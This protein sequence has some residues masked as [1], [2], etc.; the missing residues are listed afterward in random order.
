MA[1]RSLFSILSE[2]PWWVSLLVAAALFTLGGFIFPPV[3]PFIALPFAVIALYFAWKQLTTVSP[4]KVEERLAALRAMPWEQ[5]NRVV[6]EAY[7][8]RGYSVEPSRNAAFDFKLKKSGLIT[9][10][11]C[12]R[13]KVN[14]VGLAPV[15]DLYDEM[16]QHG[17]FNAVCIAAHEFSGGAR[18]F[19]AGKPLTL[20]GGRALAELVG[21]VERSSAR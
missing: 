14:Q 15:R 1:K 11:Q 8:R 5:F 21:P 2:Q 18:E 13:W 20:L 4:A 9:L 12:R 3:A 17:A 16:E 10:V 6:S 7:G 19:A